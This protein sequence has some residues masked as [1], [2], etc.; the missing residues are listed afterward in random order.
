LRLHIGRVVGLAV[1]AFGDDVFSQS[2][3]AIGHHASCLYRLGEP[4]DRW[5]ENRNVSSLMDRRRLHPEAYSEA[6]L[7]SGEL[8]IPFL[9]QL[10]WCR[11]FNEWDYFR[12]ADARLSLFVRRLDDT[13]H[14]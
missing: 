8:P 3:Y 4:R 1:C 9:R 11:F 12:L 10:V 6:G 7:S 14:Q 5:P 13:H 2:R